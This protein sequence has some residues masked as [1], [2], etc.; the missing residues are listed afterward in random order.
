MEAQLVGQGQEGGRQ[1]GGPHLLWNSETREPRP[2]EKHPVTY[3]L[4]IPFKGA[5][6]ATVSCLEGASQVSLHFQGLGISSCSQETGG[7]VLAQARVRLARQQAQTGWRHP[8]S[9]VAVHLPS[10]ESGHHLPGAPES[11]GSLRCTSRCLTPG[12]VLL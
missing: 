11:E 1:V 6:E 5:Q 8:F 7:A 4:R 10:A 3:L 9:G 2:S 12:P